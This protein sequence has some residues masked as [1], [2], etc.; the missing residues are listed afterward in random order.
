VK[1]SLFSL[2]LPVIPEMVERFPFQDFPGVIV[3][4]RK[5]SVVGLINSFGGLDVV[6]FSSNVLKNPSFG[7]RLLTSAT[8]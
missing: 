6:Q 3:K 8:S 4:S 2:P 1:E 5:R 7:Y